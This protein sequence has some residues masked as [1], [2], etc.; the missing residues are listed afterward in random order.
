MD[1]RIRCGVASLSRHTE[2]PRRD[3]SFPLARAITGREGD[4]RRGARRRPE[5]SV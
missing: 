4:V 5:A 1:V 2:Y 3:E